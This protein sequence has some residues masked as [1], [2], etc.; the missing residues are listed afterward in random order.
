MDELHVAIE[1]SFTIPSYMRQLMVQYADE[2]LYK[3][4]WY[5]LKFMNASVYPVDV[6]IMEFIKI[7]N[8]SYQLKAIRV[9]RT[10]NNVNNTTMTIDEIGPYG[11]FPVPLT[12]N[13]PSIQMDGARYDL[14]TGSL[15][16][17][18]KELIHMKEKM[19]IP[20]KD[21]EYLSCRIMRIQSMKN[22]SYTHSE[23]PCYF[24]FINP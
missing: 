9:K 16:S 21:D 18:T 19:N 15:A 12:V 23:S 20:L 7:H 22:G 6:T 4:N 3:D 2:I 24:D 14:M 10:Y 5:Y 11:S 17:E 8:Y 13:M 1:S